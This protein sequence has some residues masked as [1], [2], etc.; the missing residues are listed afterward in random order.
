[1]RL[2]RDDGKETGNYYV[3]LRVQGLQGLGFGD[4]R[5]V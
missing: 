2:Y 5:V 4:I 1:M 3:R